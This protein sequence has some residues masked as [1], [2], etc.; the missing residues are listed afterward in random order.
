M[1]YAQIIQQLNFLEKSTRRDIEN[2]V[3]ECTIFTS[4]PKAS[5]KEA[6]MRICRYLMHTRNEGI[7]CKP[8]EQSMELSC[9]ADFCVNRKA[10][11]AHLDRSRAKS[12]A[13][14]VI[15]SQDGL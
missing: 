4:N 1:D 6:V 14:Y 8:G 10:D 15:K 5:H 12:R 13:G 2:A 7:I 11:L 9:N 3:H